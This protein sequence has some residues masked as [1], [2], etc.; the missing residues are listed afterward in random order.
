MCV[1]A[2]AVM[3]DSV[4]ILGEL[5]FGRPRLS[6]PPAAALAGNQ[7]LFTGARFSPKNP[8]GCQDRQS[9]MRNQSPWPKMGPSRG[10][11]YVSEQSLAVQEVGVV[12][13][14]ADV[15]GSWCFA[16]G[17]VCSF[18]DSAAPRASSLV[19]NYSQW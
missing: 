7:L 19:C 11:R 12:F 6:S 5:D 15:S 14:T 8:V 9:R 16:A 2:R 17:S 13:Q 3:S 18:K 1:C 10:A 4:S